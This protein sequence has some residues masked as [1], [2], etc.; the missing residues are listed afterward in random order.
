MTF[1]SYM[2]YF[3]LVHTCNCGRLKLLPCRVILPLHPVVVILGTFSLD[4]CQDILK[5][6]IF[7]NFSC[8]KQDA[9]VMCNCATVYTVDVWMAS[10][11]KYGEYLGCCVAIIAS[12][13]MHAIMISNTSDA[14]SNH[15]MSFIHIC[16]PCSMG[17]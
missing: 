9:V 12:Y 16:N 13:I 17:T 3:V 4:I 15:P 8:M 5:S 10:C 2:C 11:C 1:L 14:N 6:K 7:R